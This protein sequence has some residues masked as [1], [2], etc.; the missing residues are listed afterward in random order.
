MNGLR[1]TLDDVPSS[2]FGHDLAI[3]ITSSGGSSGNV[4]FDVSRQTETNIIEQ[5]AI[6]YEHNFGIRDVLIPELKTSFKELLG[7][8]FN[9]DGGDNVEPIGSVNH[10]Q[11]G[12]GTAL[13]VTDTSTPILRVDKDTQIG[14][15]IANFADN[16]LDGD[17]N[18]FTYSVSDN[19]LFYINNDGELSFKTA[20]SFDSSAG[21]DNNHEVTITI[22]D[23][24]PTHDD[25]YPIIV[26]VVDDVSATSS[27]ES[28]APSAEES[29]Y[30]YHDYREPVDDP[31]AYAQWLQK[32]LA[33][34]GYGND[35]HAEENSFAAGEETAPNP[36]K[37][38]Q[39]KELQAMLKEL[40]AAEQP[41]PPPDPHQWQPD[42][43]NGDS[44]LIDL[45]DTGPDIL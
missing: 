18:D 13:T 41:A 11:L 24:D 29:I 1:L 30:M 21:A 22:S 34:Q 14:D 37:P 23:G 4:G 20:P 6:H 32:V 44:D 38:E 33:E 19:N 16:D 9:V 40:E 36:E 7:D 35:D 27:S 45:P 3:I 39:P 42:S 31:V 25:T 17:L 8:Y 10:V 43:Y 12:F 28:T 15:I 5:I 2:L 26:Q